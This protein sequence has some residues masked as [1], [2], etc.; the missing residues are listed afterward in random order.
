MM[1][2]RPF[3]RR[4][5]IEQNWLPLQYGPCN[6]DL[7]RQSLQI[8]TLFLL[9]SKAKSLQM[10]FSQYK[11]SCFSWSSMVFGYWLCERILALLFSNKS[12]LLGLT[13]NLMAPMTIQRKLHS[14]SVCLWE[15]D[16]FTFIVVL[17]KDFSPQHFRNHHSHKRVSQ[18]CK[19]HSIFNVF[20]SGRETFSVASLLAQ[21][22][23]SRK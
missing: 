17:G 13:I 19:G 22:E 7:C 3:Q 21:S 8:S 2:H 14:M 12:S 15:R 18:D 1:P 4:N 16:S 9:C 6:W 23:S 11:M 5:R 10:A 20:A